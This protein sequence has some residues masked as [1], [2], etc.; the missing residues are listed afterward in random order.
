MNSLGKFLAQPLPMLSAFEG[1][2][3]LNGLHY[4]STRSVY[5]PFSG[6]TP[7]LEK[8]SLEHAPDEMGPLGLHTR[9]LTAVLRYMLFM[10]EATVTYAVDEGNGQTYFESH[11]ITC[12]P[13][14]RNAR[15][16]WFFRAPGLMSFPDATG[17]G[18]SMSPL[19]VRGGHLL[20][21]GRETWYDSHI[22]VFHYD[23][24]GPNDFYFHINHGLWAPGN[25]KLVRCEISYF[26][27]E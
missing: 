5:V 3:Y 16:A 14:I 26:D 15:S 22:K 11:T 21:N 2:G 27:E 6:I 17:V 18:E 1:G 19:W 20:G 24:M 13:A 9:D 10:K 8:G 7:I 4:F 12:D 25:A 23:E